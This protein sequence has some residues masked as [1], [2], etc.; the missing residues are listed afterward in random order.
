MKNQVI[1]LKL[2]ELLDDSESYFLKMCG[3]HRDLDKNSGR[4]REAI[5]IREKYKEDFKPHLLLSSYPASVVSKGE[6][7]FEQVKIPCMVL[8]RIPKKD[9]LGVYLYAICLSDRNRKKE[10][11]LE[12]FYLDTWMTAFLDAGRDWLKVYLEKQVRRRV[13]KGKNVFLTDSFGPGFYGM[14]IDV[15]EDFFCLLESKKIG[16]KLQHGVMYP[17]KSNVGMYLAL[18]KETALPKLDCKNCLSNKTT[19]EFCKNYIPPTKRILV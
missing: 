17:M 5:D 13:P 12:E 19:C 11:M 10:D 7:C 3:F 15:V 4:I 16:L 18:S 14:G 9:I 8:N 1:D 2:E 6:F